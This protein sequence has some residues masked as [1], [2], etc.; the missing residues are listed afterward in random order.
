MGTCHLSAEV[1]LAVLKGHV[2][3]T[4]SKVQSNVTTSGTVRSVETQHD[5]RKNSLL[6]C[7]VRQRQAC[8]RCLCL[9]GHPIEN[10]GACGRNHLRC[11][12]VINEGVTPELSACAS[13]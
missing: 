4:H 9:A 1:E 11:P 8:T 2:Q 5:Y 10:S 12:A 13:T 6:Q 3:E 7:I